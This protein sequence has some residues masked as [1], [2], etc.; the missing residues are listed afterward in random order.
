MPTIGICLLP[1]MPQ[2]GG[3][4]IGQK[5]EI[6]ET[7]RMQSEKQL[8]GASLS[9]GTPVVLITRP[10]FHSSRAPSRPI[11]HVNCE[12]LALSSVLYA[13][14]VELFM[15]VRLSDV[16]SFLLP[17]PSQVFTSDLGLFVKNGG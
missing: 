16:T 3:V 8:S 6:R 1:A 4:V 12:R 10:T 13:T 15:R 9:F 11:M 14:P 7:L 5:H 2:Y 17:F